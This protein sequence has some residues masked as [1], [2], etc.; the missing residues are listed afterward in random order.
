ME[1]RSAMENSR[2]LLTQRRFYLFLYIF[3]S[4]LF[5]CCWPIGSFMP[6]LSPCSPLVLIPEV[7]IYSLLLGGGEKKIP[8]FLLKLEIKIKTNRLC[9]KRQITFQNVLATESVTCFWPKY[10]RVFFL[11]FFF[12]LLSFSLWNKKILWIKKMTGFL[13]FF[14]CVCIVF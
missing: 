11:L 1:K 13:K 14:M 10:P 2:E 3:F 12:F 8:D 7:V 5:R 9:W 6:P 4:F